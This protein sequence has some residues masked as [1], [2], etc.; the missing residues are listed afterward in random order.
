MFL[1]TYC[2]VNFFIFNRFTVEVAD[3]N[4]GETQSVDMEHK[5]FQRRLID[6]IRD[7]IP[8][9]RQFSRSSSDS[10]SPEPAIN[11]NDSTLRYNT[12]T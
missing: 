9:R 2:Y 1:N 11:G 6:S 8:N 5:T 3:F 12:M 10:G 4:F 7:A